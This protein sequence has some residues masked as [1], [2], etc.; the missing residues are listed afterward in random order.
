MFILGIMINASIALA[1]SS[2]SFDVNDESLNYSS[3]GGLLSSDS[4]QMDL[5][6]LTWINKYSFSD[7]FA[8][9]DANSMITETGQEPDPD[10]DPDPDPVPIISGGGGGCRRQRVP[11]LES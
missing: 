8:L 4:Y 10:P 2:S 9:L 1:S 11:R 3:S 6:D 5:N 7:S